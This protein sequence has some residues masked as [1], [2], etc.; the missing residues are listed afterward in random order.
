MD[1]PTKVILDNLAIPSCLTSSKEPL[2]IYSFPFE[3][4]ARPSVCLSFFSSYLFV[5]PVTELLDLYEELEH[6]EGV[7]FRVQTFP[8]RLEIHSTGLSYDSALKIL[9]LISSKSF[10]AVGEWGVVPS[11]LGDMNNDILQS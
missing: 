5:E 2:A 1:P 11:E 8:S 6:K 9:V 10:A 3:E 4:G 7:V